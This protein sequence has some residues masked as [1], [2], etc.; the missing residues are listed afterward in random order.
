LGPA[1]CIDFETG[2]NPGQH[3]CYAGKAAASSPLDQTITVMQSGTWS[4]ECSTTGSP[5]RSA[6]RW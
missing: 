2:E 6:C 3:A 4:A 1:S 5:T